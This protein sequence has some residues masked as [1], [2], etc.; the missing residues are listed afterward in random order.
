MPEEPDVAD[1]TTEPGPDPVAHVLMAPPGAGRL[2]ALTFDD[3]PS[4]HTPQVLDILRS[5][6]VR[7]TFFVT[8]KHVEDHADLARRVAAE[9]HLLANHTHN[10]PQAV[11]GSVPYGHFDELPPELQADEVDRTTAAIIRVTGVRPRFF[12]GPAGRHHASVALVRDRGLT[13]VE[14]NMSTDD[15]AQPAATTREATDRI[16]AGATRDAPYRAI[17]LMHDGKASAEP[18]SLVSANRGNTVA[19]LPRIIDWY[20]SR[21][22]RFVAPDGAD[23]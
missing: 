12:R 19:A 4:D 21:G 16:V 1:E 3:G 10:H 7:A 17:V 15:W 20:A 11:T 14:W 8:G 5:H 13:T 18:E 23:L 22:Y 2:V 6:G 9:G